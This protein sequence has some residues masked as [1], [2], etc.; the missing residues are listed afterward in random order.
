MNATTGRSR[1]TARRLRAI[2]D[3]LAV[4]RR[5]ARRGATLALVTAGMSLGTEPVGAQMGQTAMA[6]A[7]GVVNRAVNGL[8]SLNQ[9]GPG[10]LYYGVNAADRGLGYLG[11]YMTLGGFV[12]GFEDDL[13]GFW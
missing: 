2:R 12:P 11:S 5:Q 10:V 4:W 8:R 9:N 6:P 7:G 1:Q 3:R 13:G